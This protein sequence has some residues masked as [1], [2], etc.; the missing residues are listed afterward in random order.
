MWQ[1]EIQMLKY[2]EIAI[3]WVACPVEVSADFASVFLYKSKSLNQHYA[4]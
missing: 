3:L 1:L 2:H 4:F